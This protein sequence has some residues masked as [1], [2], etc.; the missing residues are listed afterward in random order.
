MELLKIK[1]AAEADLSSHRDAFAPSTQASE[2]SYDLYYE[3]GYYAQRYPRANQR[4]MGVLRKLIT[5][6]AIR[7]V[8]DYGCGNGR[9]LVPVLQLGG[10]TACGFDISVKSLDALKGRLQQAGLHDQAHLIHKDPNQITTHYGP[11]KPQL[12][13]MMFG[14]LS[15]IPTQESRIE[16]LKQIRALLQDGAGSLVLSVPN[17]HRRFVKAQNRTH[18]VAYQR[19]C[20]DNTIALTYH[21]YDPKTIRA[22]LE[23]AG[24]TVQSIQTESIFPEAWVT[25]HKALGWIDGVLS[26]LTPPRFG[27]GLLCIAQ[28]RKS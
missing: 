13:M 8:L 20:E 28:P 5:D 14:V 6:K 12:A 24:F 25:N 10:V 18:D 11:D 22:D 17:R 2:Q 23:A 21:L 1:Q 15:H 16:V 3:T 26:R 9:Y 19:Q 7:R 4:V 27:Y